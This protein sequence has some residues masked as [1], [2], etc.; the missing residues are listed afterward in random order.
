MILMPADMLNDDRDRGM[1]ES[2]QKSV[3]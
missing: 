2:R 3:L 1:K